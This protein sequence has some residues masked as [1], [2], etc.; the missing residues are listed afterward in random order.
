MRVA[1][2]KEFLQRVQ[3]QEFEVLLGGVEV[4]EDASRICLTDS[5]QEFPLDDQAERSLANYL[6]INR[7]YIAK[8]PPDLAALNF[9][10]WLRRR[11]DAAAVIEVIDGHV[12]S[13]HKPNLTIIP[14][15]RVVEV[16]TDVFSPDD[17]VV[18]LVRSNARFHLDVTTDHHVEVPTDH[19]IEGRSGG[20][21][22][23]GDITRGGVRILAHPTEV[24]PP[25]VTRYLHRLW[26]LN[27]ATSPVKEG[28]IRLKGKT[29][30]DVIA[31]ME[32]ACRRSMDHL[33]RD[34]ADYAAL[35]TMRPPGSPARFAHRLCVESGIPQKIT[36]RIL[37]DVSNLPEDASMYDVM[38]VFTQTAN[39]N[40]T[41]R[42]MMRLQELGGEMAFQT[43]HVLHRCGSCEQL[44]P[45]GL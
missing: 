23:V 8:C 13:I 9:N 26:C 17:E 11:G 14:L 7:S 24:K 32:E 35:A 45:D 15:S 30:D 36:R 19:R 44:L 39:G 2:L 20:D 10:Y 28:T 33:D 12:A 34:L 4:N 27:G 18:N 31:E 16:V 21:R 22:Q 43:A 41:Y 5:G 1:D 29:V 42:S 40:V 37:D 3:E 38:Q 25:V 6:G